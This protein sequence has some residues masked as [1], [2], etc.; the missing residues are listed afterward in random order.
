MGETHVFKA[1]PLHVRYLCKM[2]HRRAVK[3][4][5]DEEQ[6][7]S[8]L[9]TQLLDASLSEDARK[10]AEEESGKLEYRSKVRHKRFEKLSQLN[11]RTHEEFPAL[12]IAAARDGDTSFVMLAHEAKVHMDVQDEDLQVT[13]LIMATVSNKINV[14]KLLLELKANQR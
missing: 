4:I 14:V 10:E 6:Q 2:E 8:E 1:E 11:P 13:P 3:E 9:Q 12:L 7:Y 5:R